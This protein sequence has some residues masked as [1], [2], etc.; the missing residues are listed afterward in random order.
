MNGVAVTGGFELALQCDF[1]LASEQ[2]RFG[3]TH[4]RVGVLPGWGLSVLLPP[5]IATVKDWL[6]VDSSR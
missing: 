1:L 5:A 4:A 3:D 6:I 2:A